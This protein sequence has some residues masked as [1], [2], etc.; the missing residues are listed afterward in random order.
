M[1]RGLGVVLQHPWA[2]RGVLVGP[3]G[4]WGAHGVFWGPHDPLV[5][6]RTTVTEEYRVPDGMVGLSESGGSFGGPG[7]SG[8]AW[9]ALGTSPNPSVLPMQSSDAGGSRSTRSSRIR[10]AKCRSPQVRGAEA[11]KPSWA[12]QIMGAHPQTP[13]KAGGPR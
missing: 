11:P 13:P 12:P 8:T 10:G 4:F 5:P 9:G 6:P 3:G 2:V 7:G 1:L